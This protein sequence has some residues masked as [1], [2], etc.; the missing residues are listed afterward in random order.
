MAN[1]VQFSSQKWL[2]SFAYGVLFSFVIEVNAYATEPA[3]D[4]KPPESFRLWCDDP[5]GYYPHVT[6]CLADWKRRRMD[7]PPESGEATHPLLVI[8]VPPPKER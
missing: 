4:A 1:H 8:P 6:T 3:V 2:T 5:Q 7:V